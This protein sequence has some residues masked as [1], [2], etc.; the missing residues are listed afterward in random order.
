MAY[1]L[2][3]LSEPLRMIHGAII[4]DVYNPLS[5]GDPTI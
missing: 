5:L 2:P 4:V 3:L 1:F